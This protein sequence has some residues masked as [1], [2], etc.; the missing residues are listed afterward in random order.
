MKILPLICY[1]I[2][3]SGKIFNDY[4]FDLIINISE[5]V[6]VN[7]PNGDNWN[8]DPGGDPSKINGTESN[9]TGS[10]IQEGGKYPDTEDLDRSTFLDKTDD[11]FSSNFFGVGG[12]NLLANVAKLGF[13]R[14]NNHC[15]FSWKRPRIALCLY[16]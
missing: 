14:S 6:D 9:G 12:P 5:D 8:Y 1:E 16:Q 4:N 3:Y 2:I 11:Y 13:D 7:D 10:R 15:A